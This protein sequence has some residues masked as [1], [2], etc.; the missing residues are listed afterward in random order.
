MLKTLIKSLSNDIL[1]SKVSEDRNVKA[2]DYIY[3]EKD[4][5][6]KT[7]TKQIL[8]YD[9][10][11]ELRNLCGDYINSNGVINIDVPSGWAKSKDITITYKLADSISVG[12]ST[13]YK[14]D[15]MYD[16]L[17]DNSL[18]ISYESFGFTTL[19]TASKKITVLDEGTLYANIKQNHNE[20]VFP[21]NVEVGKIDTLGPSITDS[22]SN[23]TVRGNA[24]IPINISDSESGVD[25][26]TISLDDFKV[27][28]GGNVLTS[29]VT[30][31]EVNHDTD[32]EE[33][34]Y[35]NYNL[36]ISN[37]YYA[38]E[39][40]INVDKDKISDKLGNKNEV[41]VLNTGVTFRNTYTIS[42][43]ANNGTGSMSDTT[44]IYGVDCLLR[45]NTIQRDGY[46]FLGWSTNKNATSAMYVDEYKFEPF[47]LEDDMTLYAI[48]KAH[49]Y[50]IK[51]NAN[52][53]SG[54]MSNTTCIYD[55]ECGLSKNAF[56]R[57]GYTYTLKWNTKSNGSGTGYA[58]G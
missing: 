6:T 45:K 25:G 21:V 31:T 30:L 16:A 24:T 20:I 46:T 15:Y 43:D 47:K 18:D 23:Q 36:I 57:V 3:I 37:R 11:S 35:Y 5:D 50:M 4:K 58:G 38:G 28:I 17:N 9:S 2:N 55:K 26:S 33:I 14:Y 7:I 54:S 32:G 10:N 41:I 13:N 40:V 42:Y 19:R 1:D 44:C 53:G 8:L 34:N 12:D 27:S 22:S 48:W 29:G 51:Y 49:T 56:S 39:V 52:G